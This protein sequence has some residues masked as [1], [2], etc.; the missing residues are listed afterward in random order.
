M[1]VT[2]SNDTNI[3]ANAPSTSGK[4]PAS[5]RFGVRSKLQIAFG[6]VALMT[7]AAA[8]VGI[9]S[10]S[11]TEREFQRVAR[12]DVPMMTDALRLSG[13]AGEISASPGRLVLL[14]TPP[15]QRPH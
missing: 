9:V 10:F 8:G 13:L 14:P 1:K 15:G 3:K 6:A 4:A 2:R 7:V 5:I 11:A 12:H